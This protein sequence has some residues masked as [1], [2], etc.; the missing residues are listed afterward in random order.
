MVQVP[1]TPC[2]DKHPD[3]SGLSLNCFDLSLNLE[4]Y[5]FNLDALA[6]KSAAFNILLNNRYMLTANLEHFLTRA[7]NSFQGTNEFYPPQ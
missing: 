7:L 5:F 2:T 4:N 6:G 3:Q 1:P